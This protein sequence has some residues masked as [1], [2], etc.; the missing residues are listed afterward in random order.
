MKFSEYQRLNE[1]LDRPAKYKLVRELPNLNVYAFQVDGVYYE[2]DIQK[3]IIREPNGMKSMKAEVSFKALDGS[4]Y[5]LTKK[6]DKTARIVLSTVVDAIFS[7]VR[8]NSPAQITYSAF[9][10]ADQ[11]D[12]DKR[13]RLYKIMTKAKL[14]EFPEYDFRN[15][16]REFIVYDVGYQQ[17]VDEFSRRARRPVG[18]EEHGDHVEVNLSHANAYAF[19][20]AF[21]VEDGSMISGVL[22]QGRAVVKAADEIAARLRVNRV[23]YEMSDREGWLAALQHP[24][25]DYGEGPEE[26]RTYL[27]GAFKN[28]YIVLTSQ[29]SLKIYTDDAAFTKYV[30]AFDAPWLNPEI[31]E[32]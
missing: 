30:N 10:D 6:D 19:V 24:I 16:G 28:F 27:V 7:F 31:M 3:G 1:S 20:R 23:V 29:T 4:G 18:F 26:D 14:R 15:V 2:I 21:E 5:N 17:R 32:S 22:G 8:D 25:F 9:N 12:A 11:R 13:L